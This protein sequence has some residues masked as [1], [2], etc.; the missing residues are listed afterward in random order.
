MPYQGELDEMR[1]AV[2]AL[3]LTMVL[4]SFNAE[5]KECGGKGYVKVNDKFCLNCHSSG[6]P[7]V[8]PVEVKIKN[9]EC[10]KV[11]ENFPRN[12]NGTM[13]CVTCHDMTSNRKYFLRGNVKLKNRYDFCFQ[14]HNK[15]CYRKF[16]PHKTI[17]SKL[18]WKEKKKACVY[19]HGFGA[20]LE[21]YKACVGCH[22]K[23]PHVGAP[24]HIFAK[25]EKVRKLTKG[26]KGII[27]ITSMR[28]LKPKL[29]EKELKKRKPKIILVNGRIECITC[30]NPHPQIAIS[31]PPQPSPWKNVEEKDFEYE[32][33]KLNRELNRFE[34]NPNGVKLMNKQLKSGELCKVCHSIN[35]L[36]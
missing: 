30:H 27:N 9:T 36:K 16:N 1:R 4:T 18:P 20:K 29:S 11:P 2:L 21:A 19:C 32:L 15:E 13:A 17:G 6:C 3:S 31:V 7:I 26:K 22:T 5:G 12:S 33:Q 34:F 8:H 24:E 23:T 10:I 25:A 14:C 35:S 28:E